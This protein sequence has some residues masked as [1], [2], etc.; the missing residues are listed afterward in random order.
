MSHDESSIALLGT[1]GHWLSAQPSGELVADRPAVSCWET[2]M[3]S[4]S[5]TD[6]AALCLRT[7]HGAYV[8]VRR[9]GTVFCGA[10]AA[11]S[12][13]SFVIVD[14]VAGRRLFWLGNPLT[15]KAASAPIPPPAAA[16]P[17]T[18]VIGNAAPTAIE[19]PPSS[20][21]V[22]TQSTTS[23]DA[24]RRTDNV[25]SGFTVEH[26]SGHL[27]SRVEAAKGSLTKVARCADI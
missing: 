27:T 5:P 2:F 13:E 18:L 26:T 19:A 24:G 4:P 6:P 7:S 22:R 1:H 3:L 16:P 17:A 15:A 25:P 14:A 20:V 10:D 11:G 21:T 12:D 23:S 9:D 8:S